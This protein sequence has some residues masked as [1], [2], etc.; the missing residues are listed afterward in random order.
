[1]NLIIKIT[2][3]IAILVIAGSALWYFVHFLPQQAEQRRIVEIKQ[4]DLENEIKCK[5]AGGKIEK[6]NE[7][8][9]LHYTEIIHYPGRYKV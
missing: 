8:E 2:S 6:K 1:M 4:Q 9:M 7:E 3:L 5:D